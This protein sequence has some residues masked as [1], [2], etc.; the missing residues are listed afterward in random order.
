M[1]QKVILGKR[2]KR[3]AKRKHETEKKERGLLLDSSPLS[4]PVHSLDEAIETRGTEL[5]RDHPELAIQID[6]TVERYRKQIANG[7][8]PYYEET[9]M[10]FEN[11]IHRMLPK[12]Y[13]KPKSS[14][15]RYPRK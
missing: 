10:E 15:K 12:P 8:N 11:D 3:N 9:L 13:S 5:K 7:E 4:K 6:Q 1:G 14:D 2:P